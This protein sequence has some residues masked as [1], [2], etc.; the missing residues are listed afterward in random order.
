MSSPA[1]I[2]VVVHLHGYA[3]PAAGMRLPRD[4]EKVSGLDF[5]DPTGVEIGG[6]TRPTLALL[7]RGSS[8]PSAKRPD[9]FTFPALVTPGAVDALVREGLRIFAERTGIAAPRGRLVLTAHS[10]G[11]ASLTAILRHTE[12]DEVHVFDAFYGPAGPVGEWARRRIER[13]V[14]SPSPVPPALRV[15]YV[16]G[17]YGTQRESEAVSTTVCAALARAGAAH[18]APRFRVEPTSVGH[19]EIPRRFGWRLLAD[20]GADLPGVQRHVC[21]AGAAGETGAAA[22]QLD[23]DYIS[24]VYLP[25]TKEQPE[26]GEWRGAGFALEELE[27]EALEPDGEAWVATED[28]D[29]EGYTPE[30]YDT[31][32]HG[33]DLAS[34][35]YMPEGFEPEPY[36][37]EDYD[38]EGRGAERYDAEG[39]GT[40]PYFA[41][42]FEPEAF[43]EPLAESE[44]FP[45]G[46][47]LA[48]VAGPVGEGQ[49]HWD[50]NGTGLP[51][52]DTGPTVRKLKLSTNF[53]VRELTSSGGVASDRARISPALVRLLQGI[54]D[55]M[56]RPVR[57]NSGYRSWAR[58]QAV[59]RARGQTPTKSRHCSGQAADI[60][61]SGLTGTQIAQLAI[62]AGGTELGIGVGSNY[63]HVDVRGTWALWT[64]LRGSAATQAAGTVSAHRALRR[65]TPAPPSPSPTLPFPGPV[66]AVIT[67]T[68]DRLRGVVVRP[69]VGPCTGSETPGAQALAKQ[70]RRLTGLRTDIY[71]CRS[72]RGRNEASVH[73]EGRAIDIFAKA[74]LPRERAM[75]DR[76][77]A[78]LITNAVELQVVYIIWNRRQW[79]W[80]KRHEGVN[81]WRDYQGAKPHT[82][83]AHVELSWEGAR[84]PSPLFAGGTSGLNGT[85]APSPVPAPSPSPAPGPPPPAGAKLTPGQFLARYGP[86]ARASEAATGVPSLV[87]LGQAA[88]E[89]GWGARAAGFNFFGIKARATDPPATRQLWHTREVLSRPDVKSFPEVISVTP[90]PDGRYDYVVRDWFRVYPDAAAA[91]VGHGEFLRKNRRYAAAFRFP[92]D[93]YAFAAEVAKAGYATDPSYGRILANVMRVLERAG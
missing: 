40:E 85:P 67:Q 14:A 31:E 13:E 86:H 24:D 41:E 64:Y 53:T 19:G 17:Q 65:N 7:P 70:W 52:L 22:E 39:F 49:E 27:E 83:H 88:L 47:V 63:A 57:V 36:E 71:N 92:T 4:K 80:P 82:D 59:Y 18:L 10:G 90:R 62:D 77:V 38:S 45:A 16:P 78:W 23:E 42:G 76:Y 2:D 44:S 74:D 6:R 55:R 25:V 66:G 84:H 91:F 20:A 34:G 87:T 12:P 21:G 15:V 89:S 8:E 35:E 60:T 51:L 79:G 3:G 5:S 46:T 68:P 29:T 33:E 1:E 11:G 75:M 72:V 37:A 61:I 93:P 56:G 81:G 9:R 43:G 50:P 69:K 73:G 28:Y 58:N 54:R 48:P 32:D 26:I 30:G